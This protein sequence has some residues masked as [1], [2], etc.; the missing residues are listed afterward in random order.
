MTTTNNTIHM[1]YQ[2]AVEFPIYYDP[3]DREAEL[4][5]EGFTIEDVDDTDLLD[6][7]F[8][9]YM[10]NKWGDNWAEELWDLCGENEPAYRDYLDKERIAFNDD[11]PF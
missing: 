9:N 5:A 11:F 10:L 8:E 1:D 6:D 3:D 2:D 7:L 4:R